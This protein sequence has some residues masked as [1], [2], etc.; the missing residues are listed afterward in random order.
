MS[1]LPEDTLLRYY[2]HPLTLYRNMASV[3]CHIVAQKINHYMEQSTL[4]ADPMSTAVTFYGLNHGAALIQQEFDPAEPLPE[5]ASYLLDLYYSR[6]SAAAVRAVYYLILICVRESRHTYASDHVDNLMAEA[7]SPAAKDFIRSLNGLSSEQAYKR[8]LMQPPP[9]TLGQLVNS[10]H[11]A[12]Y[13]GSFSSSF[14]GPAWGSVCDCLKN[15]VDG[16]FSMEMMLDTVWTL[17]HNNGP[18]FNKGMLY[19]MYD[20]TLVRILDIQRSGQIPEMVL[21]SSQSKT[22]TVEMISNMTRLRELFPEKIGTYVD[23]YK[24]EGLGAVNSYDA[25][26][27]EQLKKYGMSD[28]AS[29]VEKQKALAEKAKLEAKAKADAEFAKNHLTIMPGIHVKKV[30]RKVA[31]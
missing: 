24:V 20:S 29:D 27:A 12:F 10:M 3:P 21:Q 8:L 16:L 7:G 6:A 25:E 26:K 14:G 17:A 31:A 28:W 13:K 5:A 22:V 15:T 30:K 2:R 1:L 19:S 11:T 9:C 18:I 4:S 23:W